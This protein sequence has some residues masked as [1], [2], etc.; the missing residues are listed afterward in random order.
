MGVP[1]NEEGLLLTDIDNKMRLVISKVIAFIIH[2][3]ASFYEIATLAGLAYSVS[4]H[5]WNS[6]VS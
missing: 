6:S 5:F 2:S 4:S 3:S 1:E